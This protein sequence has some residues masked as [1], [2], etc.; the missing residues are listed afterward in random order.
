MGRSFSSDICRYGFRSFEPFGGNRFPYR[1]IGTKISFFCKIPKCDCMLW[2]P[3]L[4]RNLCAF[5]ASSRGEAD[6]FRESVRFFRLQI[7]CVSSETHVLRP[8]RMSGMS[9]SE[10]A[11][12]FRSA[13]FRTSFLFVGIGGGCLKCFFAPHGEP[14]EATDGRV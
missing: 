10:V 2:N 1:R 6:G 7:S 5:R 11:N 9:V 14:T 13:S 4:C 3:D 8:E 12:R